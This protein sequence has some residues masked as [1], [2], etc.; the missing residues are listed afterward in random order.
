MIPL[1]PLEVKRLYKL[2]PQTYRRRLWGVSI[3]VFI[4]AVLDLLGTGI[5]LPVLLL[6]LNEKM[7]LENH[8]MSLLYHWMGF[9]SIHSF[10]FFICI[11]FCYFHSFAYA[12]RLGCNTNKTAIIFHIIL[13]FYPVVPLLLFKRIFVYQTE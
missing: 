1:I 5:L 3:S 9:G 13:S 11:S 2:L 6:V 8:Y 7:V 4:M 12:C 10:I